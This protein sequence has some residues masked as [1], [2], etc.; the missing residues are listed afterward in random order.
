M[1]V[2]D[3]SGSIRYALKTPYRYGTTQVI[4]EPL[5]FAAPAHPCTR[6]IRASVHNIAR[7]VAICCDNEWP[8]D[9]RMDMMQKM[10]DQMMKQQEQSMKM[11]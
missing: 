3:Q 5:D 6:G 8:H 2:A 4:F 7:L 9:M 11:K 10:M 1:A